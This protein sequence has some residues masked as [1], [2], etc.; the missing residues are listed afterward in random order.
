MIRFSKEICL[1]LICQLFLSVGCTP[2]G[3]TTPTPELTA[4][5][6]YEKEQAAIR[7]SQEVAS[8]EGPGF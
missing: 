5:E 7:A 3:T 8:Q 6:A 2:S 4:L 1:F